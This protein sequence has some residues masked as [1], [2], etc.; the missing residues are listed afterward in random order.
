MKSHVVKKK[1]FKDSMK[2][3][4]ENYLCIVKFTCIPVQE[5]LVALYHNARRFGRA[6][7]SVLECDRAGQQGWSGFYTAQDLETKP[8]RK[9]QI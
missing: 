7:W 2:N 4:L 9:V 8:W 6:G 3:I 1:H 5:V